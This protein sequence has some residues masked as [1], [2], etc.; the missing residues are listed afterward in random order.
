MAILFPKVDTNISA[1]IPQETINQTL[2]KSF[3]PALQAL[4]QGVN[5]RSNTGLEGKQQQDAAT[6]ADLLKGKAQ[7]ASVA[8][9]QSLLTA[10]PSAAVSV[11]SD[12]ASIHPI[13][14]N[15]AGDKDKKGEESAIKNATSLYNRGLPKIQQTMLAAQEGLKTVNDPNQI[16]SLGT[17]RTLALK[18]FGMNRYNENEAKAVVPSTL[19]G[20]LS[21]LMNATGDDSTPLNEAQKRSLNTIFL[22]GIQGAKDQHDLLK[23]NALGSYS[24]SLYSKPERSQAL[25]QSLGSAVDSSLKDSLANTAKYPTTQTSPAERPAPTGIVDKLRGL[26]TGS[27]PA[28]NNSAVSPQPQ[29]PSAPQAAPKRTVSSSEVTEYATKHAI[30]V[31]SAAQFL[32]SQGYTI[33]Q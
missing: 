10:N 7:D 20:H 29:A 11:S 25:Q 22:N 16:G 5:Q 26:L 31:E 32:K 27:S 21:S 28:V 6:L 1:D 18:M 13:D 17:G 15:K 2:L 12:G 14:E 4:L 19:Q 33:G 8:K 30:P 9:T 23:Q 24:S 3:G